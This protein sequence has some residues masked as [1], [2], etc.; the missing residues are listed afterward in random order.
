MKVSKDMLDELLSDDGHTGRLTFS[1][2]IN[3]LPRREGTIDILKEMNARN[4]IHIGCCGHVRNI[5]NQMKKGTH[6]HKM[7][8]DNFDRVIGVDT[9]FEAV[10]HLSSY[11]MQNLYAYDFVEEIDKVKMEIESLFG[12][13]DYVILIPEVL[14]HVPNPVDFL[15]KI[16]NNY[17]E[18]GNKVVITVPNAYG[19][20]RIRE[21]LLHNSETINMDH[22]YMF[23]P[24]TIMKVMCMADIVPEEIF[25]FDLYKYSKWFRKPMLGNTIA[26]WG[27]M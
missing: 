23:T 20:G 24:T 2:K 15:R 5:D 7:L 4:V 10:G 22:K 27:N 16:K 11:G 25:F 21:G 26:V 12:S 3:L 8:V 17:S 9:N 14:E 6:F 13:E 1:S 19:F 18:K